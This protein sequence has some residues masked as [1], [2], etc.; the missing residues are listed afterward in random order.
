MPL[1][2]SSNM[3]MSMS[4]VSATSQ[5]ASDMAMVSPTPKQD[6]LKATDMTSRLAQ[7][8]YSQHVATTSSARASTG[9]Q[10]MVDVR[11]D[12]ARIKEKAFNMQRIQLAEQLSNES[13]LC[14]ALE[15]RVTL[16]QDELASLRISNEAFKTECARL[17]G[18]VDEA[19]QQLGVQ[20]T[21]AGQRDKAMLERVGDLEAKLDE[22]A[23]ALEQSLLG[24]EELQKAH[25]EAVK[26]RDQEADKV[27]QLDHELQMGRTKIHNLH[28][29]YERLH[30]K[31]VDDEKHQ[32][33]QL[34]SLK[35]LD[36]EAKDNERAMNE[37]LREL[38][39]AKLT[40]SNMEEWREARERDLQQRLALK[41]AEA[42]KLKGEINTLRTACADASLKKEAA[43]ME[44]RTEL[45]EVRDKY[46]AES[47]KLQQSFNELEV[48]IKPFPQVMVIGVDVS[49]STISVLPEIKQAYRDVLHMAKSNN[50]SVKVA[51]VIHGNY[52]Q[53][54]PSPVQTISDATFRITDS[55]GSTGGVEDY[56]YCLE[57]AH[58]ILRLYVG[59]RKSIILIG[60]GDVGGL[61]TTPLFATCEEL[62][63]A[64]ILVHSIVIPN[65]LRFGS[66]CDSKMQDI[67]QVTG[68]RIEY[69]ETYLS[70]LD[71]ILCHERE[72]HFKAS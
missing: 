8:M 19:T 10:L 26:A 41:G 20:I 4:T 39:D 23:N 45:A 16:L 15:A 6:A 69:K 22:A 43:Q 3:A 11:R 49:G 31:H 52:E 47:R 5:K 36:A 32:Q 71:E 21:E 42:K 56:A 17:H 46:L 61:D 37:A 34:E 28:A 38:A 53:H 58:E 63:S 62:R 66:T 59:S 70:A 44:L 72:L 55:I 54:D 29:M 40:I 2:A 48:A 30:E 18:Q 27:K 51:V 25:D 7:S 13:K 24:R 60:D 50:S 64:K 33:K 57:K 9:G 68:G 1:A 35:R 65:G 67:S 14:K 12:R